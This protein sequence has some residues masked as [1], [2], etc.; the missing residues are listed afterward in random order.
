MFVCKECGSEIVEDFLPNRTGYY[1]QQCGE[2]KQ[3]YEIEK[4]TTESGYSE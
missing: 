1:C 3:K 4:K 2:D